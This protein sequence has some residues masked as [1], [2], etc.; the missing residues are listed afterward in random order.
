MRPPLP[1]SSCRV[2]RLSLSIG[3]YGV[4]FQYYLMSKDILHVPCITKGSKIPMPPREL[5]PYL[6]T[7]KRVLLMPS[8]VSPNFTVG[9]MMC[10]YYFL[11][12]VM[13]GR[14]YFIVWGGGG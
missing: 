2:A 4:D 12:S 14:G 9:F 6:T 10:L 7:L 8:L 3:I 5:G 1:S 11:F 13:A